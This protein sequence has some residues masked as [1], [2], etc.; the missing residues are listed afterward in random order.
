METEFKNEIRELFQKL[1]LGY[2]CKIIKSDLRWA[3]GDIYFV[4]TW[5]KKYIVIEENGHVR[6]I[7]NNIKYFYQRSA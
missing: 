2:V 1:K 5:L 6:S 7:K 4:T 3:N